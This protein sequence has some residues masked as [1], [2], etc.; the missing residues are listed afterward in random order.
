MQKQKMS[1]DTVEQNGDTRTHTHKHTHTHTHT[2]RAAGVLSTEK[3]AAC[4]YCQH[5]A[6]YS[7][8]YAQVQTGYRMCWAGAIGD[9][10]L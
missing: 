3:W 5:G 1:V 2:Q 10:V 8:G 9:S 7:P 6:A 4:C